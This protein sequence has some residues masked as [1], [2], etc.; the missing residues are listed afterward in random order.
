MDIADAGLG[1]QGSSCALVVAGEHGHAVA[2]GMETSDD[3]GGFGVGAAEFIEGRGGSAPL[4][5]G[6]LLVCDDGL[7]IFLRARH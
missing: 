1:G 4:E 7:E 6:F 2:T 5:R 3:L